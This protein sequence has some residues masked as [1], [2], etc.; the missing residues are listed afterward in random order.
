MT[1]SA[2]EEMHIRSNQ[3]LG[4]NV[5]ISQAMLEQPHAKTYKTRSATKLDTNWW[6]PSNGSS[7]KLPLPMHH[8]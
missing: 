2:E 6:R 8:N 3:V 7:N 5:R 1:L 4:S